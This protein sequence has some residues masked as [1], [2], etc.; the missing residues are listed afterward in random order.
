MGRVAPSPFRPSRSRWPEP[1]GIRPNWPRTAEA[2]AS[3]RTS[4]HHQAAELVRDG[5]RHCRGNRHH[6]RRAEP[7]RHCGHVMRA[8]HTHSTRTSSGKSPKSQSGAHSNQYARRNP[9]SRCSLGRFTR[10]SIS[11]ASGVKVHSDD[12]AQALFWRGAPGLCPVFLLSVYSPGV[13]FL[14]SS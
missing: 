4:Q 13:I 7:N 14:I 1:Q 2:K 11:L 3:Q 9:R 10:L 8:R 5:A 12:A 6:S